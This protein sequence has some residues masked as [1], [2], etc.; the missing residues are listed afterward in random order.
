MK[1]INTTTG[2][3]IAIGDEVTTF[4]GE[5]MILTGFAPPTHPASTGRVYVKTPGGFDVGFFPGVIGA[6]IV[7][8]T[9]IDRK[10]EQP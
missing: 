3:P 10:G 5:S 6:A 4:R 8:D 9:F 7:P 1:L 2:K